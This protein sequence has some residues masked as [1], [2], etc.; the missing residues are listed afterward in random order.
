MVRRLV[1]YWEY[2][3]ALQNLDQLASS[4]TESEREEL[5]EYV[6]QRNLFAVEGNQS[7]QLQVGN[8]SLS[9]EKDAEDE[10]RGLDWM[11]ALA[12]VELGAMLSGYTRVPRPFEIVKPTPSDMDAYRYLLLDGVRSHYWSLKKDPAVEYL[13]R[14]K[15]GIYNA[16]SYSRRL[17]MVR[18]MLGTLARSGRSWTFPEQQELT[19]WKAEL[20]ELSGLL[21]LYVHDYLTQY[22]GSG[23]RTT[24]SSSSR[25]LTRICG[26][27]LAGE[28]RE[29]RNGS[30]TQ[31]SYSKEGGWG[32][33]SEDAAAE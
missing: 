20:D 12:R 14:S 1:G 27:I 11:T 13:L 26:A 17:L 9:D 29:L 33:G 28:R 8:T 2:L 4:L 7:K 3:K 10:H 6:K 25:Y 30:A 21:H 18:S 31:T 16:L 24:S 15:N 32:V 19:G 23:T 22:V 5:D